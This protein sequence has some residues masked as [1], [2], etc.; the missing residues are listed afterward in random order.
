MSSRG[1]DKFRKFKP[2]IIAISAIY[3]L[4]PMV[5][6]KKIFESYRDIKGIKGI[7]LRYAVLR[8]VAQKCGD[9]VALDAGCFIISPE[10]LSIG[11]NV[12]INAM[13]YIDASGDIE[14][15]NDVSIAHMVT[16]MSS[17]HNYAEC[18]IPIKDQGVNY[19]KTKINDNVW[20]GA[21]TTILY[22][23]SIGERSIVGA[24]SVVNRDVEGHCI[25]AGSPAKVV[26]EIG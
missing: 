1:R 3:Y 8:T 7:V 15:G 25:V 24:N 22:G 26:K 16:V 17:S 11:N 6:R 10:N 4:F 12:S 9:N 23:V 2:F 19:K 20:I 13:C 21:K 14:I 18:N 5:I